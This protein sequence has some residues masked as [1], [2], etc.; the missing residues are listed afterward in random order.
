MKIIF[1]NVGNSLVGKTLETFD[2]KR[3]YKLELLYYSLFEKIHYYRG[4]SIC[5]QGMSENM[6]E[7]NFGVEILFS[8]V[9]FGTNT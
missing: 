4:N 5:T 6:I 3:L 1:L 2:S 9:P 8:V 7:S